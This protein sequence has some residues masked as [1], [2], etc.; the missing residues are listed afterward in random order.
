MHFLSIKVDDSDKESPDKPHANDDDDVRKR[1]EE[2]DN[3]D[4]QKQDRTSSL[5]AIYRRDDKDGPIGENRS[6]Q[7]RVNE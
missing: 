5:S 4:Y 7:I 3:D 2:K 1:D 6:S